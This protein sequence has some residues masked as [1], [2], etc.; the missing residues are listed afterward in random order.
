M[1]AA[2]AADGSKL[3]YQV[4]GTGSRG[5]VLIH[6]W[7]MSAGLWDDTLLHLSLEGLKVVVVDLRGAGESDKPSTGYSIGG[8]AEDVLAV[9]EHAGLTRFSVV[10]HS[11]GGQ[12]AQWLACTAPEK[13]EALCLLCSVP[14]RGFRVPPEAAALFSASGGNADLIAKVIDMSVRTLT[15]KQREKMVQLGLGVAPGAVAEGFDAFTTTHFEDKLTAITCPT[16]VIATDDPFLTPALLREQVQ[17][18][19]RGARQAYLPGPGHY[20]QIEKSRETAALL[21]AF[22]VGAH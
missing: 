13:I 14:A 12:V 8:Y 19:I 22:L 3:A 10:G 1:S 11:M 15:S 4:H 18:K 16:L 7:A 5:V 20:P 2:K 9:A 21:E 17:R 6:G